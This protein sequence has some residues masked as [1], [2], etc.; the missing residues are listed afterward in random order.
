MEPFVVET[1]SVIHVGAPAIPISAE[2]SEA[3]ARL[4]S[5]V[6][7]IMEAHLPQCYIAGKMPKPALVL[8]V[9][10]VSEVVEA[11]MEQLS[12]GFSKIIPDG[13]YLDVL[14]IT[15]S[16]SLL[17]TIRGANCR[18]YLKPIKQSKRWLF[19]RRGK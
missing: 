10:F 15:L 14:A 16:S 4:I 9:I 17:N 1:G 19:W 11:A 8:F 2:R 6:P 3:I 7:Q 18:I 12:A 5:T 13:E